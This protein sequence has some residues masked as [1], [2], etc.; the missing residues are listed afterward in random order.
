MRTIIELFETSVDKYPSNPFLFENR[1]KG[2]VSQSYA[3]VRDDVYNL[4]CGLIS[5]GFRKGDRAALLSEG[6]N[7]WL[8]SELAI[9]Y[10]GGI[11]VPLSVKLDAETELAFRIAHSGSKVVFVSKG[12]IEKI[13]DIKSKLPNIE[14]VVVL[15]SIPL[16]E[17]EVYIGDLFPK[18]K[19]HLKNHTA[20]FLALRDSI[21]PNDIANISYTSG[22]TAD[23]KG[24]MLSHLNYAANVAQAST[25]M[26]IPDTYRTLALLPWDHAFAHTACLYAFMFFGAGIA[27]VQTGKTQLET[28]KNV[29]KN[30]NEIKPHVMM[31]VPALAKNFK[32]NI[33][34]GIKSKGKM[35]SLLFSAGLAVS[36]KYN[37]IGYDKGKG[38]RRMLKPL[39]KMFDKILFS[40]VRAGFGGNLE[41]FVGGG[42]LL[43]IELQ[44]FFYAIGIPMLQ[45]Y[46]LSEA[47]PIISANSMFRHKLGS[48]GYLVKNMELKIVD[49]NGYELPVNQ[50]GEIIVKG[51]NVMLGYWNNEKSTRE[52][53]KDGWLYT[54]D[55]GSMDEEGFLY[56][57]GR[58]K[59][60]LISNDGEKYSPEGIE[61]AIS[62]NSPY[63]D[64]VMLHNNQNPYTVMF[65]VPNKQNILNYLKGK[66]ADLSPDAMVDEAL[67]LLQS[68]IDKY[69]TG[70]PYQEMFPSRW[71]PSAVAVLPESFNEDNKLMNSTMKVVRAKVTEYFKQ[72]LDYLYKPE[73]KNLNNAINRAH[74]KTLLLP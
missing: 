9:L 25:L 66:K 32:K 65:L 51:D 68:E 47:S 33:E 38:A 56:V 44:R 60:L 57:F 48:S 12:H 23:P 7:M 15:D 8:I 11:N 28:L 54:G 13:R 52:T 20:E 55:L 42:A 21:L 5:S 35:A 6:R 71:I 2:Y 59:S 62:D 63:I 39:V 58:F 43:D 19:N 40:K 73:A 74:L 22:T 34:G 4:A 69:K 17:K 41:F 27:S 37:G 18:G 46:G 14:F 29:P 64:Q 49:E 26:S 31:S 16:E 3:E 50:K 61:E 72:E 30:I 1:G 24:I 36:C 53:L 67:A 70:G 10:C 45:G